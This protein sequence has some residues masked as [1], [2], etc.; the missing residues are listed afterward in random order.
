MNALK[1]APHKKV[2]RVLS[3]MT[4]ACVITLLAFFLSSIMLSPLLASTSAFFSVPE[5]NDFTITDFYNLVA[6]SRAVSH[7]DDNIVIVNIDESNRDEIAD[8]ISIATLAGAK[9]VC[10]DVMFDEPREGDEPL[11]RAIGECPMII[12][13]VSLKRISESVDT[14]TIANTSFFYHSLSDSTT[15]YAAANLP[16]KF[17]KSVIREMQVYFPMADGK[18][19]PSMAAAVARAVNPDAA[20]VLDERG[21]EFEN[22]SYHSRRF[23]LLQP[24]E[25]IDNADLLRDRIVMIGALNEPSDLHP[26]PVSISM[27]GVMI[28]AHSLATIL[29]QAYMTPIPHSYNIII[30]F[31]LCL[32]IVSINLFLISGAKGLLMRILQVL[33]VWASVQLGYWMFVSHNIIM[34]F[35]YALLMLTFGLFAC[36]I[37]NGTIVIGK[38]LINRIKSVFA[39]SNNKHTLS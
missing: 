26:T 8:I 11:L 6:D 7:L 20:K 16:S 36:D 38:W 14:F 18:D 23:R 13:P 19:M 34:D 15:I 2:L 17:H 3:R 32:V 33:F 12:Q 4:M 10:L 30:A 21:N 25:L 27:S 31:I 28:H 9:A 1:N 22:I 5:R 35:S 24:S 29:D 39:K 37:W